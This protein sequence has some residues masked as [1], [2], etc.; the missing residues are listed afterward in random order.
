MFDEVYRNRKVLVTGHTGFKGSWLTCWLLDLGA[1]VVGYSLPA[2]TM[3]SNYEACSLG[4]RMTSITGDVRDLDHLTTVV[5][6]HRPEF[7]FHLAAQPLVRLS[8]QEPVETYETNIMGVVNLFEAVRRSSSI[9]V[10]VNITSDKCYE[11]R[12]WVWGYRENDPMGGFDPYSS[13][14]GCSELITAAY[15]RSFFPAD[16][17]S[18]HGV[19]IASV[20]AGNVIGGGDWASERLIPDCIRALSANEKIRIRNPEAIRPWQHVLEP[21]SGY[22][23]LASLLA[24]EPA[25]YGGAWNFGPETADTEPVRSVV[26]HIIRQWGEG[27]WEYTGAADAPHEANFLRL[28]CSKAWQR[29][30]WAPVLSLAETLDRTVN[31]YR[32]FYDE[33]MDMFDRNIRD[34]GDYT[35]VAS[36]KGQ[37]WA[38]DRKPY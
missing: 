4:D 38:V 3:P 33:K 22:L 11:N 35:K 6:E 18:D 10:V 19:A 14:K 23:W 26:D 9:R 34:I 20:R 21:L 36:E 17:Y 13:S 29:L 32:L 25:R 31:W 8:Y 5:N 16:L 37:A 15:T 28:D 27:A 24:D 12:E 30:G 1:E 7:I 2:P